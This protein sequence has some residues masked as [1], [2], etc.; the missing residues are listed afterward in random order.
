MKL[1]FCYLLSAEAG[2]AEDLETGEPASCY[3]QVKIDANKLPESYEESHVRIGKVLAKQHD[4]EPEWVTPISTE[5][6]DKN[7]YEEE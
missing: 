2:M 1:R 6:Y 5:Q 7:M 3:I 4:W